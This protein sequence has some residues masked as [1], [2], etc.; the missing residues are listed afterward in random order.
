[1]K[2]LLLIVSVGIFLAPM[3]AEARDWRP[4]VAPMLQGQGQP[5]KKGPNQFRRGEKDRRGE[6][7]KRHQQR[8]TDEERRELHRDLDRANREIYRR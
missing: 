6:H 3:L 4:G 2:R 5:V 8:L 1:M 7:D